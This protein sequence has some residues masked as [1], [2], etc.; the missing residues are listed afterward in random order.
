MDTFWTSV[1][2]NKMKQSIWITTLHEARNGA[3]DFIN[4]MDLFIPI[5]DHSESI[6]CTCI[7]RSRK[8]SVK[9]Q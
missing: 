7:L 3:A 5:R 6:K 9:E 2:D 1:G 8:E 4:G